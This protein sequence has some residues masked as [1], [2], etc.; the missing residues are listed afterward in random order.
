MRLDKLIEH[1]LKTTRKEQKRLFLM[2]KVF[3][4]G[5]IELNPQRN[6]DSQLHKIQVAGKNLTTQQVYYL[7][8]KPAGVVT[9]KKDSTFQTVTELIAA[10]DRPADLYPV[11]RLDRDTTGLLLL[12]DN[13]QL[14]YDL[15]QPTAK[16]SKTYQ[17][18]VNEQVTEKDVAAFAAGI[19]FHGGVRCQPAQLQILQ[20]K[21]GAS[22]VLLTINEGKFHQVKKMFLA[23]GKKVTSLKR[24]SMGPLIL[25]PELAEG[26]YRSLTLAELQQLKVYF[27]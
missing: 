19:T 22:N 11:G 10:T 18:I 8:N 23:C 13:G 6:V 2:K 1:H 17:A 14:G 26:E 25:P 15:L 7:L 4:D 5:Q 16:V 12:T 20:A 27:R 21:P 9:A 24:L 3:V